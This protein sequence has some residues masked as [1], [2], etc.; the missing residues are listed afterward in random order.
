[1][2]SHK[3]T[4]LEDFEKEV[5]ITNTYVHNFI[6]YKKYNLHQPES[7]IKPRRLLVVFQHGRLIPSRLE[8]VLSYTEKLCI[9]SNYRQKFSGAPFPF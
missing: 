6:K 7:G 2:I 5:C 3:Y 1:M 9:A 4:L 8:P